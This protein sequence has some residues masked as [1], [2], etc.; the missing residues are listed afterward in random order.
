LYK[1]IEEDGYRDGGEG[2]DRLS[3][4][5]WD[6]VSEHRA[7]TALSIVLLVMSETEI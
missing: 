4:Y 2:E 6:R 1:E 7:K 5:V 3:A